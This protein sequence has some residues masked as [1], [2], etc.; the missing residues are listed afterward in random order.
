MQLQ[1]AGMA[2]TKQITAKIHLKWRYWAQ[3]IAVKLLAE[4]I[5]FTQ[6][7][8]KLSS[9]PSK[10]IQITKHAKIATTY[11]LATLKRRVKP[12]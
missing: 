1:Q 2:T 10:I 4:Q 12:A 8:N 3:T 7:F 11:T 5:E 9:R 6:E